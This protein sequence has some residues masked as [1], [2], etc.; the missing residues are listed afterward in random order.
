M[1]LS[2]P[3]TALIYVAAWLGDGAK[4]EAR[5]VYCLRIKVAGLF[6]LVQ[7]TSCPYSMLSLP[8]RVGSCEQRCTAAVVGGLSLIRYQSPCRIRPQRHIER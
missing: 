1:A 2:Q 3:R 8:R 5:G 7:I 6:I 4:T